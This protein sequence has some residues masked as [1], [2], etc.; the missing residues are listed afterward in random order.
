MVIFITDECL[1]DVCYCS[2]YATC[3]SSPPHPRPRPELHFHDA[4][5]EVCANLGIHWALCLCWHVCGVGFQ[6][7]SSK[8]LPKDE[9]SVPTSVI[10]R[11]ELIY[12]CS[13]KKQV[14]YI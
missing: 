7:P 12:N 13:L 3:L 2:F 14:Y 11:R 6:E 1:N 4:L 9:Y 10:I 8:K 5:T